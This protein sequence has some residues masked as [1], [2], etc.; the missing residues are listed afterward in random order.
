M[1]ARGD[2]FRLQTL[3]GISGRISGRRL[4]CQVSPQS[5]PVLIRRLMASG[6]EVAESLAAGICQ[7]IE[8]EL[9]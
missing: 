9:I 2:S 1:P 6:D 4:E 3:A 8:I 5:L 7:A